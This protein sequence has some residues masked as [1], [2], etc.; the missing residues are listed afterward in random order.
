MHS[1]VQRLGY[2][3][4]EVQNFSRRCFSCWHW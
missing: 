4:W 1:L 2:D 3:I